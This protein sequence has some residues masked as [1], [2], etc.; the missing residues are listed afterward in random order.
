MYA[1]VLFCIYTLKSEINKEF[2]K[3]I[4]TRES[5]GR[6]TQTQILR[7]YFISHYCFHQPIFSASFKTPTVHMATNIFLY[8]RK[9]EF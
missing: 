4:C 3:W 8:L 5:L 6:K 1:S 9:F 7:T 2:L